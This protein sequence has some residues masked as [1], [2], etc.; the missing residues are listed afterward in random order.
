M[1]HYLGIDV[2]SVTIKLALVDRGGRFVDS[3]YLRTQGKPIWAIQQG[4]K[5]LRA[6]M[7]E[8]T[9]IGGIGRSEER[10]VGKECRL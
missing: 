10:R 7:P 4:L 2:G 9:N 5:Q 1:S 6:R 8:N 3:V